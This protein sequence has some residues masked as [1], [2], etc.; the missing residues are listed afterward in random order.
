MILWIQMGKNLYKKPAA[1]RYIGADLF[2]GTGKQDVF[3][4]TENF[5]LH[6]KREFSSV[7]RQ[8]RK[9]AECGL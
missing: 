7:K 5:F 6:V 3:K 4:K 2:F 9:S 8:C 1:S